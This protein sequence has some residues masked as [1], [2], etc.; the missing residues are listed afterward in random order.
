M[1]NPVSKNKFLILGASR[2]GT[3]LLAA[4]LGAHRDIAVLDEDM[5][6]GFAKTTGGKIGGVKLCVPNQIDWDTKWHWIY[7]PGIINGFLRKSIF[8]AIVPRGPMSITDYHFRF[9]PLQN[10]CIVRDHNT[11]INSIIKR[12]NKS[13]AVARYR[14]ER[15]LH[16]LNRVAQRYPETTHLIRFEDLVSTPENILKKLCERL[17]LVFDPT[18]LEAPSRNER[19]AQSGFQNKKSNKNSLNYEVSTESLEIYKK[20][21]DLAI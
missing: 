20:L 3:T 7:T 21:C 18:M 6:G 8:M 17:D 11:N 10:I 2:S 9:S 13:F 1:I 19:Y 12:E 16:T 5:H 15:C 14:W 4:A